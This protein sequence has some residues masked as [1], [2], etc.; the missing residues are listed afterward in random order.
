MYMFFKSMNTCICCSVL[1]VTYIYTKQRMYMLFNTCCN[2][3]MFCKQTNQSTCDLIY[4][5]EQCF[6][7]WPFQE[8]LQVTETSQLK[9][10]VRKLL[11]ET[12]PEMRDEPNKFT[13]TTFFDPTVRMTCDVSG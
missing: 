5:D 8:V 6:L 7:F 4:F 9:T 3:N 11:L 10:A 12:Y 1:V 13:A 2:M